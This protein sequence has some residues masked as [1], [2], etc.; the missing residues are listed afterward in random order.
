M[1][2]NSRVRANRMK[3][4][5]RKGDSFNVN[6]IAELMVLLFNSKLPYRASYFS[7]TRLHKYIPGGFYV[8]VDKFSDDGHVHDL[9]NG[10]IWK[11]AI[12]ASNQK[13]IKTFV[14]NRECLTN[15]KMDMH[16]KKILVF[17]DKRPKQKSVEFLGVFGETG[18][19]LSHNRFKGISYEKIKDEITYDLIE[20]TQPKEKKV[21]KCSLNKLKSSRE[22]NM[23]L[24]NSVE[25][26]SEHYIKIKQKID[27]IDAEIEERFGKEAL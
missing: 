23:M 5:I 11:N 16:G 27:C 17:L 19:L 4:V 2:L 26:D 9:G 21:Q 22:F 15:D 8:W 20:P 25:K 14:G 18:I 10:I 6:T 7:P 1:R 13:I 12:D 3:K 24:L